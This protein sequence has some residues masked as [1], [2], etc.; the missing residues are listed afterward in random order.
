MHKTGSAQY[1]KY[2]RPEVHKSEVR[3][4]PCFR[5]GRC[6]HVD[7]R[8]GDRPHLQQPLSERSRGCPC[9]RRLRGQWGWGVGAGHKTRLGGQWG[10]LD[11]H[12]Q[13]KT[14]WSMRFAGHK[15]RLHVQCVLLHNHMLISLSSLFLK[16]KTARRA[17]RKTE[18]DN[19]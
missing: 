2:T 13:D 16:R 15:R 12:M 9:K 8:P 14:V 5:L 17:E 7:L 4:L 3:Y 18:G 6:R 10:L 11:N 1:M 19:S